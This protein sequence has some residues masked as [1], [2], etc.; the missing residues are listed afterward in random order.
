[1]FELRSISKKFIQGDGSIVTIFND[2]SAIFDTNKS[3]S[4]VGVSGTGKSTLLYMLAG[5]EKPTAGSILYNNIDTSRYSAEEQRIFLHKH[6]GLIFQQPYLI[7]ELSV[8]D[9]IT[10]KGRIMKMSEAQLIEEGMHLLEKVGLA[11]KAYQSPA[12]LSGGEQQRVACARA[13]FLK[14]Q[15]VIADEPTAHL[16]QDNK[17]KIIELL[18]TMQK[19][20]GTGLIMSTHDHIIAQSMQEKYEINDGHLE[21]A[22]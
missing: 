3:Y 4:I 21:M 11:H 8:I 14:P 12:V 16:D 20:Y 9:N 19:S 7:Q 6:V 18:A 17:N 2:A 10:L 15:F 5:I 13:M 22:L 1:M